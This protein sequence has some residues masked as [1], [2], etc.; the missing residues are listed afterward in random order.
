MDEPTNADLM[1]EIR[2]LREEVEALRGEIRSAKSRF[3]SELVRL[4]DFAERMDL[5]R[6]TVYQSS[7][8]GESPCA[9]PTAI[10]RRTGTDRPPT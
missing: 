3:S 9:T 4:Q 2:R 5:G 10:Q 7:V 8:G 6:S 1:R